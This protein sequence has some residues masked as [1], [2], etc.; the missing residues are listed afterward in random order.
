MNKTVDDIVRDIVGLAGVS[1]GEQMAKMVDTLVKTIRDENES[2][3]KALEEHNDYL[4]HYSNTMLEENDKLADANKTAYEDG[5][6]AGMKQEHE[7]WV[8]AIANAKDPLALSKI[9]LQ[10]SNEAQLLKHPSKQKNQKER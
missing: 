1:T 9:I 2:A 4:Q 3:Y 6:K 7:K 8:L 5:V 10:A